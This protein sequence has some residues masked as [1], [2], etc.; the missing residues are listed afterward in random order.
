[1]RFLALLLAILTFANTCHAGTTIPYSSYGYLLPLA[2][3]KDLL[4]ISTFEPSTIKA[5][6][7]HTPLTGRTK[8]AVIFPQGQGF[9][10]HVRMDISPKKRLTGQFTRVVTQEILYPG[11]PEGLYKTI[12]RD[13]FRG[14]ASSR[15]ILR[16]KVSNFF[17]TSRLIITPDLY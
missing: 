17:F 2:F 4:R 16:S 7:N 1:M 3:G 12:I 8:G 10:C 9:S 6:L 5:V 11:A 15:S 13:E 14:R